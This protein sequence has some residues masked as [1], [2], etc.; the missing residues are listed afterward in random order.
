MPNSACCVNLSFLFI[1]ADVGCAYQFCAPPSI[2]LDVHTG[3][4][5]VVIH[6]WHRVQMYTIIMCSYLC[7][8]V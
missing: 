4:I 2:A 3:V 1:C 7:M 5:I 8:C 6:I